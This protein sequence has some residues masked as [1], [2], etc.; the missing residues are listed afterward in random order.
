MTTETVGI[1]FLS[2]KSR[3]MDHHGFGIDTFLNDLLSVIQILIF[4]VKVEL[5]WRLEAILEATNKQFVYGR[6]FD[7]KF[8]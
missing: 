3:Q 6:G 4:F 7:I 1:A 8:V 5:Y 2:Y